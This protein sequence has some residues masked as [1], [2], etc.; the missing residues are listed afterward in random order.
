MAPL[1]TAQ[2]PPLFI[3]IS[4][5]WSPPCPYLTLCLEHLQSTISLSPLP[6]LHVGF[7]PPS[8]LTSTPS[9]M[10]N[11]AHATPWS[12]SCAS[13]A[14]YAVTSAWRL[15]DIGGWLEQAKDNHPQSK[16]SS[17]LP[18]FVPLNHI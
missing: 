9:G 7:L 1:R 15:L 5:T 12:T 3:Y 16:S 11:E 10:A 17:W 8:A 14:S 2:T 6:A 18:P 4:S 13:Y